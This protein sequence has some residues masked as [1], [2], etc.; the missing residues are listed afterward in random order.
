MVALTISSASKPPAF[1]PG[2]PLS[3]EVPEDAT[4]A[5]VKASI[6]A[7]YPKVGLLLDLAL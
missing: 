1:A 2:L 3:I 6:A 7:K 5:D 4:V